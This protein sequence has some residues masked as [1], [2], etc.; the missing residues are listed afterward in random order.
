MALHDR[1]E[2]HND[3]RGRSDKNLALSPALSIDN[4][5]LV[6]RQINTVSLMDAFDLQGSRSNTKSRSAPSHQNK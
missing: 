2:L 6:I 1:E 3:L 4:V 5:V